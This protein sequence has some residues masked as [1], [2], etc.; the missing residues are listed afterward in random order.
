MSLGFVTTS[1][2]GGSCEGSR[3]QSDMYETYQWQVTRHAVDS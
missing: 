2:F 1:S 3:S